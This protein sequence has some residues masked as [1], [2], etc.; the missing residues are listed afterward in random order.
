MIYKFFNFLAFSWIKLRNFISSI[1]KYKFILTQFIG[2]LIK[3]LQK[4]LWL[5]KNRKILI[6]TD[7]EPD[8][9]KALDV[10]V[11]KFTANEILFIGSTVMHA[12][13]K[14]ALILKILNQLGLNT[15][16]VYQ[17]SG[18]KELFNEKL[19][20][21]K[22]AST[23]TREGRGILP[24]EELE[25]VCK[26]PTSS[27][28]LYT[29][30]L[31]VLKNANKSS[32]EIALL[33]PPT[34]LVKVLS[35]D[36]EL[37]KKIKKIYVMGGWNEL[38]EKGSICRRTTYNWDMDPAAS[39]KLMQMSD[40]PMML[41]STHAI[42]RHFTGSINSS[43][44]KHLI[45]Q[46]KQSDL[47][48]LPDAEKA[49]MSWNQHVME[50]IPRLRPVIEPHKDHQFTPADPIVAVSMITENFVERSTKVR[51]NINLNEVTEAGYTVDV[52]ENPGSSIELVER[53]NIPKFNEVM[54]STYSKR[55]SR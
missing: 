4:R 35:Y 31:E 12:A 30:L 15:I 17:G 2:T 5:R 33:A 29:K 40:I 44:S 14:K 53:M 13:R 36:Y 41:F 49:M 22:A 55:S 20:S 37:R 7:L 34:D 27:S 8:D 18:G 47:K 6:I 45:Q 21:I 25:A 11:S 32:I 50:T 38:Q 52:V 19:N 9:R 46:I 10:L 26:L 43:N 39:A 28:E 23:Y 54:M 48:S 24:D 1:Y 51:I 16:P 3:N 42:S